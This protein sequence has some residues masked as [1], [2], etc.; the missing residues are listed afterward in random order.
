MVRFSNTTVSGRPF[1]AATIEA[2]WN[3]A[4]ISREHA[5]LRVDAFG[6]LMWKEGYGNTNCKLGW[7]IDHKRPVALGG[8]D[9]LDN[10]RALQ[11]ENNRRKADLFA[12]LRPRMAA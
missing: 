2:V 9:D 1:D 4:E 10:L 7:E 3:K 5:P 6:S 11:W 12:D 8:G